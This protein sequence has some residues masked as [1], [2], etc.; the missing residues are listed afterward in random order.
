M[1]KAQSNKIKKLFFELKEI[2]DSFPGIH[3]DIATALRFANVVNSSVIENEI[4]S[5]VFVQ[6]ALYRG[7]IKV[8]EHS[9]PIYRKIALEAISLDKMLRHIETVAPKK[10]DLSVSLL[11]KLHRILFESS[12]PDIAGRFRDIDV[13]I[14]GVQKRPPHFSQLPTLMYQHLA[15]ID[16]LL[17]L[18]GPVSESNF[19]EVFHVSADLQCRMIETYPF[20]AGNWR[21]A[22]AL[23]DYV[24]L[25][26]GMFYNI[27][28]HEKRDEYLA[29]IKNSTIADSAPLQE[30]LLKSFGETLN[31]LKGFMNLIQQEL[32]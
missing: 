22:R 30:F 9:S 2:R 1:E 20:R 17:K 29:V 32:E 21:I 14:R 6:S 28:S 24:L 25:K 10:S 7:N 18:L 16:G 27:I 4:I 23:S 31:H 11:L 3:K 5:P 8:K 26:S 15:W 19:F 13:R 12:W